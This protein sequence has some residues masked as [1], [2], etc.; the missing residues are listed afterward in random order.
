MKYIVTRYVEHTEKF[1]VEAVN[2]VSAI[3]KVAH[4]KGEYIDGSLDFSRVMDN[5]NEW[6]VEEVPDGK[7]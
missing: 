7:A 2:K 5:Y 4:G 1:V 6:E 3:E